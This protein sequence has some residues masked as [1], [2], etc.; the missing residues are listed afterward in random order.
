MI[1]GI[2]VHI[3]FCTYKCPYCDFMSVVNSEISHEDYIKAL[4]K[5]I[6][7]YKG[8]KG[9]VETL[10]FGGGT[11]SLLEPKH[12]EEVIKEI[13]K[14]FNFRPSEIT[15]ECNPETFER[16]KFREFKN[17]GIDRVSVGVQSFT[18]KGL[19]AL[20]RKHTLR[21]VYTF[22]EGVFE[23]GYENVNV[24]LIWGYPSQTPKDA[25]KE[26]RELEKF[27]IKHVSAYLLTF[28]EDTPMG[29]SYR[30]GEISPPEEDT[31]V[32]IHDTLSE[33]LRDLGFER[34]E[35]SNWA[36]RGYECRHNLLYWELEEFLG[37]G[38]SAWGFYKGRRY[39]N[40]RNLYKYMKLLREG[41]KPVEYN[42]SL[43]ESELRKERIILNLR[44]R[45]GVRKE[46]LPDIPEYLWEFLEEEEG[47]VKI[48]E[49]HILLSN[50]LIS[51]IL[52]FYDLN[53]KK[54]E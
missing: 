2:Y 30:R 32:K 1:R 29:I 49:E 46:L 21:D 33:G 39:G 50:E 28:Y 15:I 25:E 22:L 53:P 44:L 16:E 3:P 47:R 52:R 24:D 7:F 19:K 20:G 8:L 34:Y 31:I 9:E 38:V 18:D 11:P 37:F 14:N 35:I 4:K 5:E 17:L 36:K 42:L 51:E 40:T 26:L 13:D 41:K 10:Y 48:K 45:K 43:D 12:L 27:P 54:M 23:L 6:N